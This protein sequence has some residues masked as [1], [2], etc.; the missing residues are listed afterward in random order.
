MREGGLEG[1]VDAIDVRRGNEGGR[2]NLVLK[3]WVLVAVA[4]EVVV[5]V[6]GNSRQRSTRDP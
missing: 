4:V 3:V 6:P 5:V 1:G 2:R